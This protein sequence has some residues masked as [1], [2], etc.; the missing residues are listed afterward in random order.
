MIT[1]IIRLVI[2]AALFLVFPLNAL[3]I[4]LGTLA[5]EGSPWD[6]GLRKIN[7]EWKELSDGKVSFKIYPGGIAGDEEDMI[8]KMRIGQLDAAGI[9]GVGLTRIYPLILN[10]QAPLLVRTDEQ[11]DYV[12]EKMKPKFEQGL[13]KKGFVILLWN[14]V[15]WVHFFSKKPVVYPEDL[16]KQKLFV[17]AG[18][19][20][21]VQ[22]WKEMGFHPVPLAVTDLMS[23]LQSGMVEAFTT[24]PLSAATNQW[25]GLA[26]NM[27]ELKW[28]P[29]L[30]GVII[31]RRTWNRIPKNL[32]PKLLKAA[33]KIGKSMESEIAEA[34]QKAVIIMKQHGLTINPV[35]EDAL[36]EWKSVVE[37]GTRK[38]FG[39]S[40]EKE[41]YNEIEALIREFKS[42]NE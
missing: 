24:T 21:G 23:S 1:P 27:C 18:D 25:F 33:R 8:R 3:T 32:R 9:T 35:S 29:L 14:K 28:A 12:L 7:A 26:K 40:L 41:I 4:K 31:S 38:V 34:D 2:L 30:G 19:A 11:L 22:A 6:N 15:G 17:W 20:D 13:E 37:K 42:E 36:Q 39:N 16:M 10:V 5:P